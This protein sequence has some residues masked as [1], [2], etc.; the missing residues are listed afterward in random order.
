MKN[1][2]DIEEEKYLIINAIKR[3]AEII[4]KTPTQKEYETYRNED[5]MS[6]HQIFYRFSNYSNA[7]KAAG[8]APNPFQKPPQPSEITKDE[9]I[10]E[11]IMVA[12]KLKKIPTN[13]E[14]RTNSKYSW[15]PYKTKWG[16]FKD[17]SKYIFENYYT[18]F[19]FNISISKNEKI[20]KQ[21]RKKLIYECN[22]LYEPNNE[23]ETIALFIILSKELN[24]KIVKI[25]S[26]FP[27]ATLL[28]QHNNEIFIEFEYL[29]SNYVQH[30]HPKDFC[31]KIIC[32]RKDIEIENIEIISLEDY[33]KR[34]KD[35]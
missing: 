15:S 5:E 2:Y 29:S 20:N 35:T 14:F 9:L 21:K 22:L 26:D 30:C 3:I 33:I 13:Y 32:W 4:G 16:S 23:I 31:G 34:K 12:N 6:I 1:K 10:V 17:A 11:Y 28:D 8:L 18:K 19:N 24:Y 25:Q 27:D 7:V